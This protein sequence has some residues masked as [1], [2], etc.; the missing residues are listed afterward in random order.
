MKRL[1]AA[2]FFLTLRSL[3]LSQG[4]NLTVGKGAFFSGGN[5]AYTVIAGDI[6]NDG[7]ILT[8]NSNLKVI[9]KSAK[10]RITCYTLTGGYCPNIFNTSVY[11]TVLG[12]VDVQ[13]GQGI[14][15]ETNTLVN[16]T[17]FF[18]SGPTEIRE[19]NYFLYNTTTPFSG[20]STTKFFVTTGAY[21]GL[22]KRRNVGSTA[23]LFPVGTAANISNYT[24]ASITYNSSADSFGVR[25]FD[26][27]YFAYYTNNG[28]PVGSSPINIR[29]VEKTWIV[30]KGTPV[31]SGFTTAGFTATLQW[32]SVN[33]NPYFTP[34]RDD[35]ISVSRNHDTLWIPQ[36]PQGA[37]TNPY[38]VGPYTRTDNVTYDNAFYPYYPL[39]VSALNHILPVMG[40]NLKAYLTGSMVSLKWTTLT[41][42]NTAYFIVE[43]S[44]N[45]I[46]YSAIGRVAAFGNSSIIR[47]YS[48][49][50]STPNPSLNYYRIRAIDKDGKSM[51]SNTAA[52]KLNQQAKAI[53]LLSNPAVN[54][55]NI[56]FKN[57]PGD[58]TIDLYDNIGEKVKTETTNILAGEEI[59]STHV[60]GWAR[61]VYYIKLMNRQTKTVTTLKVV[62]MD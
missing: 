35:D 46:N 51:L 49:I 52:V 58:Y 29:F 36:N 57:Q 17:H 2:I 16:G 5:N 8:S 6:Q 59:Y 45:G 21:H 26:N 7:Q 11:N 3:L 9:G 31:T 27:V 24:P 39:T 28:D 40:L 53:I 15:I 62:I 41:E 55:I 12:N 25:V 47:H 33:E 34:S 23:V 38:S 20:N 43:R 10:Q 56:L 18:T 48:F 54:S 22:L 13:N 4:V 60:K 61:G 50:D 42:V 14:A 32:N 30:N 37:S 44:S 1:F 19:G